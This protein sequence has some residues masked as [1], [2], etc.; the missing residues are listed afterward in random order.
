MQRQGFFMSPDRAKW[1]SNS[2]G[3]QVPKKQKRRRVASSLPRPL[4]AKRRNHVWAYDSVFGPAANGQQL[5]CMTVI[6]E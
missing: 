2:A 3:L 4:P 5:K 6:E 1:P